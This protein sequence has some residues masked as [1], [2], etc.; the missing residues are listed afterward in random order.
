MKK[1][2]FPVSVL[3][4]FAFM[5]PPLRWL[6]SSIDI[7]GSIDSISFTIDCIFLYIAFS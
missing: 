7:L 4:S 2:L 3:R 5:C 6:R 1:N